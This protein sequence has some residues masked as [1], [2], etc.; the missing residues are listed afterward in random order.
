MKWGGGF[1]HLSP[2]V[3]YTDR[4]HGLYSRFDVEITATQ[5]FFS[6]FVGHPTAKLAQGRFGRVENFRLHH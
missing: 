2:T 1:F 3:D 4:G 6:F 5:L